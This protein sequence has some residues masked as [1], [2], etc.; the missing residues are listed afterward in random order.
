MKS[1]FSIVSVSEEVSAEQFDNR[2]AEIILDILLTECI[3]DK[4]AADRVLDQLREVFIQGSTGLKAEFKIP[5]EEA[6]EQTIR[7]LEPLR[8]M[9]KEICDQIGE[10]FFAAQLNFLVPMAHL[11]AEQDSKLNNRTLN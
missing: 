9:A 10:A 7:D 5:A 2:F 11:L 8:K 4:P 3:V 1:E 6:S